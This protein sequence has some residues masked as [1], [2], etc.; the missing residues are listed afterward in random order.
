MGIRRKLL[1]FAFLFC[2]KI[3]VLGYLVQTHEKVL[4]ALSFNQKYFSSYMTSYYYIL[5]IQV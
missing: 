2:K 5:Q 3:E 4:I 1:S